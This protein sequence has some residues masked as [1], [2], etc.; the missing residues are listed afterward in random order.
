MDIISQ[1][2]KTYENMSKRHKL[3]AEFIRENFDKAAYMNVEQLSNAVGVSEATVVR[4]SA[5]LGYGKFQHLQRALQDYAKSRLTSVQRMDRA[6]DLYQGT[7]ILTSVLNADI[8][9]IKATLSGID[10]EAFSGAIDK[11]L[12]AENI[13]II[14][15]R[16]ASS[17]AGF[18]GY[19]LNHM[20]SNVKV[21][22]S[23]SAGEMFEQIFR[24]GPNDAVIGISF[25]RYS[26]RTVRALKY[27]KKMGASVIGITD[28]ENSPI[29]AISDHTLL[30]KS[31]MEFFVD[32]LVAPLSVINALVVA[33]GMKR[34]DEVSDTLQKLENIW[35]D[36]DVYD[37]GK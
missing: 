30:A 1:I 20:F 14:G 7:D 6:Y 33:L 28:G 13:Y 26:L 32:S 36:N 5:E 11:I 12:N 31:D 3:L 23:A 10:R 19:Y 15:L 4:F 22:N 2:N 35:Q 29:L 21:V 34:K 8:E 18:L 37:N 25:P 9:K 16:S 27:A 24:V 17:L